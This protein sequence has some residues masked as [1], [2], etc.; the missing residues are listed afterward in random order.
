MDQNKPQEGLKE[1][2]S[3]EADTDLPVSNHVDEDQGESLGK[4]LSS[5]IRSPLDY[6]THTSR[7]SF[8]LVQLFLFAVN[9]IVLAPL[10]YYSTIPSPGPNFD[11]MMLTA[12]GLFFLCHIFLL[13]FNVP[14]SV[15]RL[16]DAGITPYAALLILVPVV[17]FVVILGMCAVPSRFVKEGDPDI[18]V[19]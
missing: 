6:E 15:R 2:V 10:I 17:G 19:E 12:W 13:F 14:L 11:K 4:S 7:K 1:E 16:R 8:W 3:T 5:W 18:V 9:A